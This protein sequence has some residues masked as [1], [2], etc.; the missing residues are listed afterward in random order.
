MFI[1]VL[2]DE[3]INEAMRKQLEKTTHGNSDETELTY[4]EIYT[5]HQLLEEPLTDWSNLG[6]IFAALNYYRSK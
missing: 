4:V 2:T 1:V 5:A 3:E 6:M